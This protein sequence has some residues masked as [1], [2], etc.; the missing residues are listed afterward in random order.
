[1]DNETFYALVQWGMAIV[2]AYGV[3]NRYIRA[4]FVSTVPARRPSRW[5]QLWHWLQRDA[6]PGVNYHDRSNALPGMRSMR[7][8]DWLGL[9]N[10]QPDSCPHILIV[11]YTG[12]GKSTF[13]RA[14]LSQRRG[15]VVILSAKPDDASWGV[16]TVS[17]DAEGD[18]N[19]LLHAI[20]SLI[21]ELKT[22]MPHDQALTVVIDDYPD[23]VSERELRNDLTELLT[24]AARIGRSKRFR[25]LVVSQEDTGRATAHRGKRRCCVIS[26]EWIVSGLPTG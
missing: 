19:A 17:Y 22:R 25:L 2:A 11:G 7:E 26:S 6:R 24:R 10:E 14:V 20:R 15:Q 5:G 16:P 13:A 1:M 3:W 4:A 18:C 12:S 8:R 9:L 21:V 23:L